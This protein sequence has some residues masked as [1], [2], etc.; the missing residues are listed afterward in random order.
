MNEIFEK[1]W[2]VVFS[3]YGFVG[4]LLLLALGLVGWLIK[5]IIDDKDAQIKLLAED[6][7]HY[8]EIFVKFMDEK[9]GLPPSGKDVTVKS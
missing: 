4:L 6:N 1:I 2:S 7:R 9:F 5:K 3:Q 8:R